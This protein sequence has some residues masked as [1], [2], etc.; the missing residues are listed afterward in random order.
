L[1]YQQQIISNTSNITFSDDVR[2]YDK[3]HSLVIYFY[4]IFKVIFS[5][6]ELESVEYVGQLNSSF[7][8]PITLD[9][10]RQR[11]YKYLLI[12]RE[13]NSSWTTFKSIDTINST[14]VNTDVSL[15]LC[16][17]IIYP[18]GDAVASTD[19]G[20]LFVFI[21]L[22]F[23]LTSFYLGWHVLKVVLFSLMGVA[24]ACI[25]GLIVFLIL[26]FV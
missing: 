13:C 1:N 3:T 23:R 8:S 11:I 7:L 6:N 14:Y 17:Q 18:S 24:L 12:G 9:S 16:S 15:G 26:R 25:A 20:S 4:F 22:K 21:F 2:A 19:T 5:F 10:N